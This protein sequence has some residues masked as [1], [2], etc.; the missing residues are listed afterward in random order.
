MKL[1]T[2]AVIRDG[3]ASQ[4]LGS[5]ITS[6]TRVTEFPKSVLIAPTEKL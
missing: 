2:T 5:W 3:T 4:C 1:L 6:D